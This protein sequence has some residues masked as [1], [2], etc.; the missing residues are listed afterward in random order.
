[1]KKHEKHTKLT[2]RKNGNYAFQEIAILG[3]KCT[4][5]TQLSQKIAEKLQKTAK[6]TYFDASH[7]TDETA[8]ILDTFTFNKTGALNTYTSTVL[9]KFNTRIQ[10][11][12]YDLV[13]IN[14]NH[15]PAAKQIVILDPEKEASIKKR[16]DQ[17][18]AIVCFV[19]K[20]N[21]AKIFDCLKNKF[22]DIN[23]IPV[24]EINDVIGISNLIASV[25]KENQ[26][27]LNGLVLAGGKSTRMGTDKGLLNYHGQAQRDYLMAL[28]QNVLGKKAKVFL[29]VRAEQ[30]IKNTPIITDKFTGLGPFGAICSAFMHNPNAA[31][32]V[33]ATDLPFVNQAVLELLISQRNPTK[34]AT[35]IKG[36]GQPFMEP[37]VTIWEPKAYPVLL[38]YLAQG[39]SCPRKVLINSAVEIVTI[40][41]R[42]IQ[43]VNTPKDFKAAQE[44][45]S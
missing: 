12:A 5:I 21:D 27:A 33:V 23:S 35:A 25:V 30:D 37:L 39:Y 18:T 17:I 41:D 44:K 20:T 8:P 4:I 10:F 2:L 28:L 42:F 29:S 24:F 19:K 22:K 31:Y 13:L 34:I 3:V 38:G 40:D 32:V 9:N 43:N 7:N 6:I 36:K 26:P 45:L 11:S 15:Y 1:M 14:G 16:I